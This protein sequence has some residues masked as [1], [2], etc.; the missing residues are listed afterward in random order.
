MTKTGKKKRSEANERKERRGKR[1]GIREDNE[2]TQQRREVDEEV[3]FL[4]GK[5]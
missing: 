4:K 3:M 1:K 5:N 2:M